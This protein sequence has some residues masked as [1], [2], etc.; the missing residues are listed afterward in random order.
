[1]PDIIFYN[2]IDRYTEIAPLQAPRSYGKKPHETFA[3]TVEEGPGFVRTITRVFYEPGTTVIQTEP[4]ILELP[5]PKYVENLDA[6]FDQRNRLWVA[7]TDEDGTYLYWYDTERAD[8][9]TSAFPPSVAVLLFMSDLNYA[10][11][12]AQHNLA[13]LMMQREDTLY[14]RTQ[15]ERFSQE[16]IATTIDGDE[17]LDTAGMSTR[18]R[19]QIAVNGLALGQYNP[20]MPDTYTIIVND[21]FVGMDTNYTVEDFPP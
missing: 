16:W 19:I 8:F 6:C 21:K 2:G 5:V 1:M 18:W 9:V 13:V 3:S 10:T 15:N 11:T 17:V 12:L 7:W 4:N 20:S 14:Y